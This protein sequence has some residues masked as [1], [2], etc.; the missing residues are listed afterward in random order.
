M[1]RFVIQTK[2]N[3][4]FL[5][6]YATNSASEVNNQ[7]RGATATFELEVQEDRPLTIESGET[8]TIDSGE[9]E[10]YTNVTVNGTL[11]VNG[12]LFT[13][14]LTNNGTINNNGTITVR[15]GYVNDVGELLSY[16]RFSGSYT[17]LETLGNKYPYSERIDN[18]IDSLV[19]GV[20]PSD[21]L[22]T[23]Y[24]NGVW[25]IVD[26]ITDSRNQ[27]LSTNRITID[28]TILA[29]LDEYADHTALESDLKL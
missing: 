22:Q 5:A 12:E 26:N 19:F 14:E 6:E 13:N 16:D 1:T 10:Y 20:E 17:P 9:T 11:T 3:G 18:S 4:V 2:S 27:P 28:L 7:T 15:T 21:Q 24:V 23:E 8:Y 25:G 29:Q